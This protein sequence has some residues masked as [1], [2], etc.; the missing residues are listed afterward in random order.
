MLTAV[1]RSSALVCVMDGN[2]RLEAVSSRAGPQWGRSHA[3]LLQLGL[4]LPATFWGGGPTRCSTAGRQLRHRIDHVAILGGLLP[5]VLA[6]GV[7]EEHTLVLHDEVD[8]LALFVDLVVEAGHTAP[9]VGD[10]PGLPT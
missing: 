2:C 3:L 4:V 9:G 1:D 6:T 8:H 5:A 7:L 10:D